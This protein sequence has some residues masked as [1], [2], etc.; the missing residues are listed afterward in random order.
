MLSKPAKGHQRMV[1]KKSILL[2]YAK[3][4]LDI[5]GLPDII[6]GGQQ[7]YGTAYGSTAREMDRL[8]ENFFVRSQKANP[9]KGIN[10][11][12]LKFLDMDCYNLLREYL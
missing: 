8:R 7:V 1:M 11:G 12:Q 3:E 6:K 2:R 9:D 5:L 4:N 10:K